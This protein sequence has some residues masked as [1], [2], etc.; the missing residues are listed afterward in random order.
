MAGFGP[1]DHS[2]NPARVP[3]TTD[4]MMSYGDPSLSFARLGAYQEAPADREIINA[5]IKKIPQSPLNPARIFS[6]LS[7]PLEISSQEIV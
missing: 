7:M 1:S 6:T 4:E 3:I 5:E 2:M